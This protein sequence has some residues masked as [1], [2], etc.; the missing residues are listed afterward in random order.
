MSVL[1]TEIETT[2]LLSQNIALL[3][4]G[5]MVTIDMVTPAGQRGRFRT[6]FI[7][8]SP[9]QYVL[10]QFPDISKLGQFAQYITKGANITVRGLT[11]GHEG[12]VVAF[13]SS[14]KQTVKIPTRIM[15]L[16]FPHSVTL[17][18]LRAFVRIDTQITAKIR[19]N[20]TYWQTTITNLSASGGHLNIEKGEKAD[21]TENKVIEIIIE[22]TDGHKNRK[23]KAIICNVKQQ[24][25]GIS[26]G[27]KFCETN[28]PQVA[29]LLLQ[30]ITLDN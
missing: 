5:S 25:E 14:I 8:Y 6:V 21:F 30:V 23:I 19:I 20:Q 15:V 12:A 17:Q 4:A 2:T 22:N 24:L 16:E 26:F 7:G 29:D 3:N 9:K 11:E 10:I 18:H 28:A 1:P 27:V 13:V